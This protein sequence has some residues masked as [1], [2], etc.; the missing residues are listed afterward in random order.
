M[1]FR[2][3]LPE[4]LSLLVSHR[5][6][7]VALPKEASLLAFSEFCP[8]AAYQI[9]DQVLCFQGHPEFTPQYANALMQVRKEIIPP[10]TFELAQKSLQSTT[11]S[12]QVAKVMAAFIQP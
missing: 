7:V 5:D 11:H 9:K 6:Q 2:S 1:L 8:N 12:A 3:F 4:Q 10:E